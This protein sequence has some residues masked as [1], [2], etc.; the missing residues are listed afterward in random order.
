VLVLL[1]EAYTM[2]KLSIMPLTI[3]LLLKHAFTAFASS[4][5][6]HYDSRQLLSSY[7]T[8]MTLCRNNAKRPLFTKSPAPIIS[9]KI[10]T[11]SNSK[12]Q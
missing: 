4:N 10:L 6:S 11:S 8:F 1:N 12:S 7:A 2:D 9:P 3:T 5:F